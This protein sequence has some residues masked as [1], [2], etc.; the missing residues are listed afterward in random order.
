MRGGV[1]PF[2]ARRTAHMRLAA[3]PKRHIHNLS[4]AAAAAR[5]SAVSAGLHRAASEQGLYCLF[6]LFCLAWTWAISINL[7]RDA[8]RKD[9]PR[10]NCALRG[11]LLRNRR[12]DWRSCLGRRFRSGVSALLVAQ[13]L[14]VR[15][16][17]TRT[18]AYRQRRRRR[19]KARHS[20]CTAPVP[21]N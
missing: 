15:L 13:F 11:F 16:Q 4:P 8:A 20:V 1:G 21:K 6:L 7:L 12:R 19:R 3:R 5:R 17:Q 14:P 18:C 9:G 10:S 2:L